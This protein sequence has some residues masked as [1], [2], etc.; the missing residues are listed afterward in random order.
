MLSSLY[1]HTIV[2]ITLVQLIFTILLLYIYTLRHSV[3]YYLIL[4]FLHKCY[5]Y[6]IYPISVLQT[7]TT[8]IVLRCNCCLVM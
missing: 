3:S 2:F 8:P 5:L 1:I 4:Y 7:L 6:V